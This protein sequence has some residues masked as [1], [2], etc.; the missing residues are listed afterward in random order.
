[1]RKSRRERWYASH[2]S[3]AE[4]IFRVI[5]LR[6]PVTMRARYDPPVMKDVQH[7]PVGVA[8]KGLTS[9]LGRSKRIAVKCSD[10]DRFGFF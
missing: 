6:P 9:V 4:H 3:D 5:A 10:Y 1:M 2:V 8:Q 7:D